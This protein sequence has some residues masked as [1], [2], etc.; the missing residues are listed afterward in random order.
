[1]SILRLLIPL[2]AL[3]AGIPAHAAVTLQNAL[4][5]IDLQPDTLAIT[6]TPTPQSADGTAVLVSRGGPAH[7]SHDLHRSPITA[8]WQWDQ[9]AYS[10]QAR[11]DGAD[12]TL[13]I[14]ARNPGTLVVLR[15]PADAMGRALVLPL[16]EGHYVPAGDPVWRDFLLQSMA[17]F[18]TSQ[19]ISLPL[20]TLDH[21]AFTLSWILANPFNN[22]AGFSRDGEGLALSLDHAF[23]PLDAGTPMT[24][25]LH[26]GGPDVLAGAKRYRTWL[27]A[28]GDYRRLSQKLA[29]APQAG[30]LIGASH[31]YLWGSGLL[32]PRDVTD[33]PAM[34]RRLQG[35]GALMTQLRAHID[36]DAWARLRRLRG[37]PSPTQQHAA[38]DALNDAFDAL[39][40]ASWQTPTPDM[41]ILARRY[42]ELRKQAAD[43]FAGTLAPD[44]TRWGS[45]V[46]IATM[47]MLRHGGLRR[48]WIGLGQ[49]WEGGL[50]HPEAIAA[51]VDA[52][53]LVAPYDS[54]ETA[55]APGENPSWASAHLGMA[56]YRD[57]AIVRRDGSFQRGFQQSGRYTDPACVRPL[58]QARIQAILAA[59]PFNSWFLDAY[60]SGMVFDNYSR[61]RPMSQARYAEES[62]RSL[63]WIAQTLQLPAGSES[64]N[65]TTADVLFAHGMQTPVIGWGDHEMHTDK[66]SR[67]FVGSWY[68]E[69][70][71][72]I[73]FRPVPV[74]EKY[75]KVHFDPATRLPLYQA[76]FHGSVITTHHWLYDSLKVTNARTENT[77]TQLLYNVPPLFHLNSATLAQRLPQIACLDA[78]FRPLHERLAT[79]S[80][81]AFEWL[82]DD[83]LVQQT[84]FQDQTRLVANF[85]STDYAYRGVR[86]P[87]SAIAALIPGSERATV[88]RMPRNGGLCPQP[89]GG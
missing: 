7:H 77:L 46:S 32:A 82:T 44:P 25:I 64:G 1:M 86:I 53:Y 68:P 21:G 81:V 39:A 61:A 38:I 41:R 43:A 18:D 79:Q 12:L 83:R 70:G 28:K 54:Y 6:A 71:P 73:F 4:W 67:Y 23:T 76:V 36:R 88:Y 69:D 13:S 80:L 74:K 3:L 40:R 56:A 78:F 63:R 20:W 11:L 50:W 22:T 87:G 31:V 55:L 37:E 19:D 47:E 2:A 89:G 60:A 16:A 5:S 15:Q 10:V 42:G 8:Q 59:A 62:V 72:A 29:D 26:L 48:L 33:W 52:G 85:R 58:L 49:G 30:R 35:G 9:G 51:G 57:C 34:V 27:Q 65:A 75:R 84:V 24:L 17:T 14:Q 66:A 45:G